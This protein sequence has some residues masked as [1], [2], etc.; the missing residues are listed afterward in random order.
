MNY[1]WLRAVIPVLLTVY[2]TTT[3]AQGVM[4]IVPVPAQGPDVYPNGTVISGN[5]IEAPWG[6]FRVYFN[7]QVG[8]WDPEGV[9]PGFTYFESYVYASEFFGANATPPQPGIDMRPALEDCAVGCSTVFG[10]QSNCDLNL[11]ICRAALINTQRPDWVF[12]GFNTDGLAYGS[13][14]NF[15][16]WFASLLPDGHPGRHDDG[17]MRYLGTLV[18]D[19]PPEA[20]TT[21]TIDVDADSSYFILGHFPA[22]DIVIYPTLIPAVVKIA[23]PPPALDSD[24]T[25]EKC[26]SI[27]LLVPPAQPTANTTALRVRLGSL[28][29]VVPPYSGGP[30]VPFTSFEGQ[31]RWVGP[32]AQYTESSSSGVLFWASALQCEPHYQDWSTVGLLHV[33]GSA[34]VPSSVY[35][36]E[37]VAASCMGVE[38]SCLAVSAPLTISTTRWGDVASPYNP[39]SPTVQP[40]IS[41]ISALVDKFRGAPGAPIKA[42]ALLAGEP[43]NPFGEITPPVLVVDFGFSHISACVDAF[44]GVPYPYTIQSCP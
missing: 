31:V 44:R 20:A 15:R 8:G 29:H 21:Y 18:V 41:D 16:S 40:D 34:I 2:P 25:F 37:N 9:L 4:Q 14:P 17:S 42:R 32:P 19:I 28:H 7:V 24:V 10:E 5:Q 36:V 38:E 12:F 23:P 33:T 6:G 35:E 30:S 39:P 11:D 27:S 1:A 26:R 3:L 22:N 13:V 43:G